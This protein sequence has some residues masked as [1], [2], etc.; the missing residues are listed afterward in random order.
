MVDDRQL[1]RLLVRVLNLEEHDP[2]TMDPAAP[3]F[4]SGYGGWGLDSIDALEIALALQQEYGVVMRSDDEA[5]RQA[6]ASVSALAAFVRQHA[7]Q[8]SGQAG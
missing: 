7:V 3:L 1:A 4:G 8:G 6:F 5:T 2:E